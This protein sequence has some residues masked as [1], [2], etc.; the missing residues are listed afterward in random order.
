LVREI[1]SRHRIEV[2]VSPGIVTKDQARKLKEAGLDRLNHNLNTSARYYGQ[3]CTTHSYEQR[4]LT[5]AAAKAEG[6]KVCSGV[7]I[8]MGESPED[9][10]EMSMKL[11]HF[12]IESIP[13]NFFMP[14]P[15]V[16]IKGVA[17]LTPEYCLRVLCLFR[18]L[19]PT[20]EI[21]MA[22]GREMHLRELEPLGL[23]VANSLF[24]QGY[25]NVRG[26]SNARTLRMIKDEGFTVRSEIPLEALLAVA[27]GGDHAEGLKNLEELRPFLK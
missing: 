27:S 13:V 10:A 19:N 25:L 7:I 1:K 8:G 16:A 14:I 11:R 12:R 20:A 17:G 4:L 6:L 23:Y 18:F 22:A 9:V 3:I 15:G 21:R 5:I 24:L 2:C 26:S